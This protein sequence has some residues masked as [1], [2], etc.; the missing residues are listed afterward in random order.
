VIRI[1]PLVLVLAACAA[2]P[3]AA[4][5]PS[6]GDLGDVPVDTVVVD[7]EP[8]VVAVAATE[9]ARSQ[10]LRGV[11]DLG[12]LDGMLF[13][14]DGATVASRFTM[15]D[16]LIA[17]DIAFFDAEGRYVDGF[18]MVPCESTV[19]PS[20]TAAY[21][22]AYALEIPAGSRPGWGEGSELE[23]GG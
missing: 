19:C 21:A 8:L 14:W 20:Y 17:L 15:E 12:D 6:T 5:P 22:H 4:D 9:V 16:T 10:G 1:V 11:T 23:I 13:T 3:D 7:G 18:T 2:A